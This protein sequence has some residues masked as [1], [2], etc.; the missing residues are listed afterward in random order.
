MKCLVLAGGSSDRLWPLSRKDYPKQFMEIREGRSM[1]QETILRNIPFC[2][3]FIVLTNKRYENIVKGQLQAFQG[4]NSTVVCESEEGA[5]KT[6][7]PVIAYA[8]DCDPDEQLLIVSSECLVDGDYAESM[9]RVREIAAGDRMAIVVCKPTNAREGYNFINLRGKTVSC[10]PKRGKNSLWDCGIMG[11]KAWVLLSVLPRATVEDCTGLRVEKGVLVS[12]R[13]VTPV[14]LSKIL[15]TDKC[16]LVPAS[17]EW[18]RIT[19][20]T[21]FYEYVGKATKN[22][23]NTIA[24]N[25]KGVEIVNTLE[26]KLVVANGLKNIVIVNTRDALYV[27]DKSREADAKSIAQKYYTGKKRYFD[28]QPKR[29]MTWGTSETLY[30]TEQI[31][32]NKVVLYPGE[33]TAYRCRRGYTANLLVLQ[34]TALLRGKDTEIDYAVDQSIVIADTAAYEIAN[35]GKTPLEML[36]TLRRQKTNGQRR[37]EADLLVRLAPV[38]KDN[39]WGGTRIRDVFHKDVGGMEIVAES[40]ELS[41]HPDGMSRIAEGEFAGMTFPEYIEAVGKDKLGWKAQGYD[42]FPVMIKFIDARQNLSIQVHPADEYAL[43]VEGQYGKSEMWYILEAEE[44]ACIYVGFNRDVTPDEVRERIRND[45]LMEVLNRVPVKKGDAYFLAAGTVHA[46]GAGCFICEVQQSS[47]VTYRLYDYGR[48]DKNGNK[49]ELHVDKAL[50]VVDMHAVSPRTFDRYN[51]VMGANFVRSVVG[52][53]K[54]FSVTQYFVDGECDLPASEAS[55]QAVVV[56]EGEGTIS[57]E[58]RSY[59]C[60]AGDTFFSAA[61]NRVTLTGKLKALVANV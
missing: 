14:N 24:Y 19:D 51:A 48:T 56:I 37:K 52:E 20:I 35:T 4:L 38:F 28:V 27:S 59:P 50:D 34:G 41:A 32:V 60:R 3:E 43:S 10:S 53:C 33:H 1:F 23:D 40:W 22:N 29:Y 2:D 55:F 11:V 18:T 12:D 45:T 7:P 9:A 47:N 13:P 8:K 26:S 49:R 44:N 25:C 5:L 15:H 39:L 31:V 6:A 42:K 36:C 61:K 57:D 30:Y 21:S 54:Y 58:S 46:I 17:F 16:D